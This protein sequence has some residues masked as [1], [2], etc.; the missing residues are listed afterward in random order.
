MKKQIRSTVIMLVLLTSA[1]GMQAQ[2]ANY[3]RVHYLKK[4]P[5]I[6]WMSPSQEG[7]HRYTIALHPFYLA[8]YGLKVDFEMELKQP[9]QWLQFEAIG[10]YTGW[11]S[12]DYKPGE[13]QD[14]CTNGWD[15]IESGGKSFARMNG[16]GVGVAFKSMFQPNGWYF[17]IGV[18]FNFYNVFYSDYGYIPYQ[19][20]GLTFFKYDIGNQNVKFYKPGFD[21]NIGK[22]VAITKHLFLDGFLGIGYD[23]SFY[24]ANGENS[25]NSGIFSYGYRGITLSGGFRIGWLWEAKR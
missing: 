24:D 8:N 10:R 19:E 23:Y 13:R 3:N 11:H 22:Q 17:S 18:S 21:F 16:G 6:N 9:G 15:T 2:E 7:Q 4:P 5:K 20:D 25:Y 1:T 14:L 12:N